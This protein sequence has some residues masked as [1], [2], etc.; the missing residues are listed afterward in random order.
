MRLRARILAALLL[1]A[2]P[3]AAQ[4]AP[5]VPLRAGTHADYGRLVFDW[6]A[7]VGYRVEEAEGRIL[8]RFDAPGAI[9]LSGLRPPRNVLGVDQMEDAV[10]VRPAPGARLRHFR[11]GNRV[12]VDLLDAAAPPPEGAAPRG[13]RA[14]AAGAAAS[15]EAPPGPDPRP[16]RG[17]E[18]A[19]RAAA[20]SPPAGAAATLPANAAR[21]PASAGPEAATAPAASTA[22]PRAAPPVSAPA[23]ASLAPAAVST[24]NPPAIAAA[25]PPAAPAPALAAPPASA[26]T[27]PRGVSALAAA[28][29]A[30]AAPALPA[31]P[32]RGATPSGPTPAVTA[33]RTAP[34]RASEAAAA[35]AVAR[36][37]AALP[38]ADAVPL[39]L[40][41]NAAAFAIP[42]DA[43]TGLALFRHG[44]WVF[45]VLDRPLRLDPAPLA[46]HPV[47]G[48][49][50]AAVSGD[51]TVLRLRLAPPAVLQ[52][53]REGAAW[54]VE[55]RPEATPADAMP[56]RATPEPGPPARLVLQGG[57]RPEMLGGTLAIADPETG[58]PLLV[59]T[60]RRPG[61]GLAVARRLPELELLP[62]LMGAAVL[63]RADR[64][65]LRAA[66]E[67][68]LV[69]AAGGLALGAPPGRDPPAEALALS[70]LLELPVA[71]VPALMERL[72][73]QLLALNETPPLARGVPRRA[74]A[75][76]LLALGM[77][78]EA[79]AMT[80]LA[81]REDP[82]AREDARLLLA[83][84][85]AALLSG[86]P[87]EARALLDARLPPVDEVLL[88]RALLARAERGAAAAAPALAAGAPLV[89][90]YP[91]ALRARLLPIVLETL[92][93]G[94]EAPRAAALLAEAE[95]APG[96][97]L[98]RA[99]LAEAAGR[100][101]EA[102]AL[103]AAVANGRDRRAR[104]QALVRAAELR[105]AT[106]ALDVA[107]AAD[108]LDQALFA[109]RGGPEELALRRRIAALRLQAGQGEAA[110]AMLQEAGRI[111]PDQAA[112]LRPELA[113]AFAVALETAPP[114][115]A[116]T[117]F[118]AHPDLLPAG[119]RG[120]AAVLLLAE[121]LAALDLAG[122]AAELLERAQ[123][124]SGPGERTR[125]TRAAIG[126][127]LAA[128]RLAE[129]DAAGA[130][131]ALDRSAAEGLD[132]SLA[133]QR[134]RLRARALV[135][136]GERAEAEAVLAAL[137]AAGA[138][139]RA[140]LRAEAQ[141]WAGAAAAQREH[142]AASLPAPPAPLGPADR[143]ALAR[144]AAYAALA[145]EE[146]ALAALR[147]AHGA[148][149]EGG[150]LA[151]AFTLLTADPLRGLADLPRMQRELGLL[152]VLPTRLEALRAGVQV[153][154]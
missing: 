85:A 106:G 47:L 137:G 98:T 29:P 9:D 145:G 1:L 46:Q 44:E 79:Q 71:P 15:G 54:V 69:E 24:R 103:Y 3:A 142:L 141:D 99:L 127:R 125:A 113:D 88:W 123:Q 151:E 12:V 101:E 20:A 115:P 138:E 56:L 93:A 38:P 22:P 49:L 45:A 65:V 75:E 25:A 152:R 114:L 50:Q 27:S 147:A 37:V 30:A 149:M 14:D 28:A 104:A 143:A 18:P 73:T 124:R 52:A 76:T 32:A 70:R 133:A 96:L 95:D 2:V 107:A 120:E 153:A 148:R 43:E 42:A 10:A 16:R 117:L 78:Q 60:L 135:R 116:A 108:A 121:R 126:A 131:A 41:P 81:L 74:A 31:A 91:E 61:P 17:G 48:G 36:A 97:D 128:L 100:T 84:G 154:R 105:H 94:G 5:R 129:G 51:A 82:R 4:D 134:T 8:L 77:P 92:A 89:L 6:P 80:V 66:G 87:E 150:P 90:A 57:L 139:A 130:I 13:A 68:I 112:A 102:L 146:E 11:L 7:R 110:F 122:R 132:D 63:A 35:P 109:W 111:W 55:A 39:R 86:R 64:V 33:E 83:Q 118:D 26:A 136:R 62:S 40:L 53:R 67:R 21:G 59:A 23:P 19:A 58:E 144:A 72:R 119:E 34:A 140:E